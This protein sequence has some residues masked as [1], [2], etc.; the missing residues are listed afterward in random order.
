MIHRE[1]FFATAALALGTPPP[2]DRV[3]VRYIISNGRRVLTYDT[4]SD[5][6][7]FSFELARL[8]VRAGY[9]VKPFSK[10]DRELLLT[11]YSDW[12]SG[13]AGVRDD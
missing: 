8:A 10:Q 1:Q 11:Q 2:L 6:V 5:V 7:N 13:Q 4:P 9:I 3:A 12:Y